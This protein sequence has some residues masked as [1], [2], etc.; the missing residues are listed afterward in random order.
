VCDVCMMDVACVY[1][2]RVCDV[3][4]VFVCVPCVGYLWHV[5]NVCGTCMIM[6]CV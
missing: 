6:A 4:G 1:M 2:W 5:Y 3:R